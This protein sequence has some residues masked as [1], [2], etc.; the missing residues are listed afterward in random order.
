[1]RLRWLD[2][3]QVLFLHVYGLRHK[4]AEKEQGQYP[5]TL[6]EQAWSIKDLL[7][8]FGEIFLARYRG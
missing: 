8:A 5:A 1:M 4:L 3:G 2:I 7:L 6:I